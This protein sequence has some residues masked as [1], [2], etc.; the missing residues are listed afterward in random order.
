MASWNTDDSHFKVVE[1][2]GAE[3][4]LSGFAKFGKLDTNMGMHDVS[5]KDFMRDGE[6]E[7]AEMYREARLRYLSRCQD[8]SGVGTR[9][10]W[11]KGIHDC[12]ERQGKPEGQ[13]LSGCHGG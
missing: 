2:V 6:Y 7:K 12:G 9:Q 1:N 13:A 10:R 4:I 11:R 3:T 8:S 5:N